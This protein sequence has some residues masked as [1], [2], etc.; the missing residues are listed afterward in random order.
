MSFAF[1]NAAIDGADRYI[2][3]HQNFTSCNVPPVLWQN[4]VVFIGIV[5][6]LSSLARWPFLCIFSRFSEMCVC[7]I[8]TLV[9]FT[10]KKRR[11]GKDSFNVHFGLTLPNTCR[12]LLF[13]TRKD[14]HDAYCKI[15]VY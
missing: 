8:S 14:V 13:C 15:Q 4:N 1:H 11:Y 9:K 6:G 7:M 2:C 12:S 5:M 10:Q 3:L